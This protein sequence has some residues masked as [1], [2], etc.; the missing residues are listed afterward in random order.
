MSL[1]LPW[2][3]LVMFILA[4]V[5]RRWLRG[6]RAHRRWAARL[7]RLRKPRLFAEAL[8]RAWRLQLGKELRM[9]FWASYP[10]LGMP[11]GVLRPDHRFGLC[12]VFGK[13]ATAHQL[14]HYTSLASERA[15]LFIDRTETQDL[16]RCLARMK[17][18]PQLRWL[19]L[20]EKE[21]ATLL[22]RAADPRTVLKVLLASLDFPI[23]QQAQARQQARAP[24]ALYGS[25]GA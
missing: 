12:V 6:R 7:G 20:T 13:Q 23:E 18:A 22:D 4:L 21:L 1:S 16:S 15:E 9:V 17:L 11:G 10:L 8:A 3:V 2:M 19:V 14:A 25:T 5:A 24:L